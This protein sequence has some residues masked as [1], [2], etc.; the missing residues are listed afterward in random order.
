MAA[1]E[2]GRIKRETRQVSET[3][4]VHSAESDLHISASILAADSADL[5]G[6]V[7]EA[8]R[9][10][11]DSIHVDIFDG[12]YVRNLAFGPQT[13]AD[14]RRR[15]ALPL[16]AH[17]EVSRPC[18]FLAEFAAAGADMIVVQED[19]LGPD[20]CADIPACLVE[21]RAAGCQVGLCV[22]PDR[23]FDRVAPYL[24]GLDM[25]LFLSVNPGFGG[26]PF[27]PRTLEKLRAAR[28]AWAR[29]ARPPR[30]A[31]DGGVNA[32]N[33]RACVAAGAEVVIVGSALFRGD[34]AENARRLRE[35]AE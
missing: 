10:G 9:G 34:V 18:D 16:H 25:L 19:T 13:V 30:I 7:A 27:Q 22:N 26:Q 29:L 6:A 33:I 17:L 5:A 35:A 3:R 14:L 4:R 20:A 15:T 32:S 31:I 11:I 1:G 24:D 12:H 8:E 21:I 2:G 23:P 28:D